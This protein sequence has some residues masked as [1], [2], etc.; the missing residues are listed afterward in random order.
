MLWYDG[1]LSRSKAVS[2]MALL[3]EREL[4]AQAQEALVRK[5]GDA[6]EYN[7]VWWRACR[8]SD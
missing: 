8:E 5:I 2:D 3:R 6:N 1:L 4:I 7:M